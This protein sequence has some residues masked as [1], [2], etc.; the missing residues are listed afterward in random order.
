ML[1]HPRE[2]VK[3]DVSPAKREITAYAATWAEI[4]G[5]GERCVRGCFTKSLQE[6]LPEGQIKLF[7]DHTVH[8]GVVRDAREDDTGLLTVCYV[9]KTRDGDELLEQV[10]DGSLSRYS[11]R[12]TLMRGRP[13]VETLMG[14]SE[15]VEIY[16]LLEIK[17]KEVGP[18]NLDPA[19][20]AARILSV[21]SLDHEGLDALSELPEIIESFSLSRGLTAAERVVAKRLLA[22]HDT[23]VKRRD[24]LE[25]LMQAPG[26][27]TSPARRATPADPTLTG[28]VAEA[29]LNR[30]AALIAARGQIL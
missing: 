5:H 16:E 7:R 6:R 8:C 19:N 11:F 20:P 17:L 30:L 15:P 26:G 9:S 1:W 24:V 3:V 4:D 23:L 10:L 21:K 27:A 29:D 18:T 28:A 25:V 22:L 13:V 2:S 14:Q 12:G